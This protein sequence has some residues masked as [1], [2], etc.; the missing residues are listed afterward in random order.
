MLERSLQL[1]L[2]LLIS[3]AG[4]SFSFGQAAD[5]SG[6]LFPKQNQEEQPAGMREMLEKMRI[7]KDKK[8]HEEMIKRG[9]EALDLSGQ[10]EKAIESDEKLTEKDLLKLDNLEKLVKKIR[11]ELGGGDDADSDDNAQPAEKPSSILTAFKSL[12][13]ATVL[14][15]DELK[16]TT[17]FSISAAAITSSNSVLRMTRFLRFWK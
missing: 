8:D 4:C 6:P 10:L 15:V 14:L 5:N 2:V 9:E 16:K 7:E 12:R 13:Q 3:L 11:G 17:R 1:V